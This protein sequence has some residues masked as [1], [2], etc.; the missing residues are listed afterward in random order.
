MSCRRSLPRVWAASDGCVAPRAISMAS[1]SSEA[2][3]SAFS[4]GALEGAK[5]RLEESW[6][7]NGPQTQRMRRANGCQMNGRR[8]GAPPKPYCRPRPQREDQI[9]RP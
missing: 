9:G 3:R 1:A 8:L 7:S 6:R 4:S 2:S 5:H